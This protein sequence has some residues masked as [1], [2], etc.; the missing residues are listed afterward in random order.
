MAR[1]LEQLARFVTV[2]SS[3]GRLY[4]LGSYP[5]M[6]PAQGSGDLVH[7]DLYEMNDPDHVLAELDRYEGCVTEYPRPYIFERVLSTATLPDGRS[8]SAWLYLHLEPVGEERR[9]VSGDYFVP[10]ASPSR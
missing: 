8:C 1:F 10:D 4:D 9:I 6:L 2:A 3:P 7:G 5:A